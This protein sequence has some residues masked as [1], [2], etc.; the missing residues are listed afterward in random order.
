MALVDHLIETAHAQRAIKNART[1]TPDLSVMPH[2]RD[3]IHTRFTDGVTM[4]EKRRF[5]D[6]YDLSSNILR[7]IF[8]EANIEA[9]IED[10]ELSKTL[11]E[12]Q[13]IAYNGIMSAVDSECGGVF[14]VDG[15]GGTGKTYLYK[16]LLATICG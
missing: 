6:T 14:F 9:S 11:N 3:R 1:I 10:L 12:E 4:V 16:A 5:D 15:L 7:E 13:H 8:Y 2:Y